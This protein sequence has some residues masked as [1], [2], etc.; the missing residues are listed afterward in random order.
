VKGKNDQ[1]NRQAEWQGELPQLLQPE[2]TQVMSFANY[3]VRQQQQ[4]F[5]LEEKV[6][7]YKE[8]TPLLRD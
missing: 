2:S 5:C 4:S 3:Q 7:D 1:Q 6:H 8:S